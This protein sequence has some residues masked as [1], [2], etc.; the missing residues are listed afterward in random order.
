MMIFPKECKFVGNA[1]T[2]PLG[3]KVYF[4]TEYLIHPTPDGIEVLK[5]QPKDGIGLMRDIESVELV[6][7][8][9]DTFVWKKEVNTHDRAGLV[10]KALSTK[11]R[12]TVFGKE[13]DHMTFVCDPDLSTFETV[14]VFDI[15]PPN[16]S[17]V[18]TLTGLESLGFFE[19]E[20]IV[21]DHH[22]RDISKL[23]TEI[24]P[25][26]AGGFPHTLDRDIPPKGSRIACCRTGRQICHENYG[27]DFEFEDICPITQVN[28]EP[29]IAR[30]CRAE[31]SGI[32][33]YNG[34][35]GAVVHWGANPKTIADALFAMIKEWRERN[36]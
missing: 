4:L 18:D 19:T 22:I 8:S 20:N 31:N 21:F 28:R 34:Y 33:M 9:K 12:C 17:L 10:R 16:P 32:G 13:D 3:D 24:Y 27:Y 30:C 11:K 36:D 35:F 23:D 26:R 15:T 6:A 14:H 1:A 2:S 7:G 29:F 25:C 5:I